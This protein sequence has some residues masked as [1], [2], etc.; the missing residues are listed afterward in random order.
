MTMLAPAVETGQAHVVR[1]ASGRVVL[2]C[3]GA[4]ATGVAAQWAARG[5]HVYPV[6]REV[7][8]L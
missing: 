4:D 7:L 1:E 5:Y 8:G 6:A 3:W 2:I